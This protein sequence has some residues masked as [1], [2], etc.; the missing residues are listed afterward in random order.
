LKTL[1]RAA[2]IKI[3]GEPALAGVFSSPN[4]RSE[5]FLPFLI[6]HPAGLDEIVSLAAVPAGRRKAQRTMQALFF[7]LEWG[8]QDPVYGPR[9]TALARQIEIN[10]GGKERLRRCTEKLGLQ[11]EGENNCSLLPYPRRYLKLAAA[12]GQFKYRIQESGDRSQNPG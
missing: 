12:L 1:L 10:C 2:G 9:L 6:D 11:T 7:L 8:P 3:T 5:L 4:P